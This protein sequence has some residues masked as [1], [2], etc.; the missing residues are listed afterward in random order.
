[1]SANYIK[2]HAADKHEYLYQP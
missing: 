2:Y 1:M